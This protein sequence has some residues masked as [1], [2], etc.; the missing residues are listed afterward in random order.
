MTTGVPLA[1]LHY[2][3]LALGD[4][5]YQHFCGFGRQLDA[6]LLGQGAVPLFER[7]EMDNGEAAAWTAWQHQL[8]QVAALGDQ[9]TAGW[10]APAFAPW[11]LAARHHLNPGSQGAPDAGAAATMT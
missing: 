9:P 10:Q 5:A 6:W 7:I 3:V 1:Q 11:T 4:S 8:A 2:A